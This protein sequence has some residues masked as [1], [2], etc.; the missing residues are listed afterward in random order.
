[1]NDMAGILSV[2]F[3]PKCGDK[4]YNL[5]KAYSII[6]QYC[7][8]QLDL[9]VLPE[10][11]TTS[12]DEKSVINEP[13]TSNG[14]E[15][16]EYMSK[17]AKRFNTNI[18]CGSVMEKDGENLYNTAFVL[19]R[20]GNIIAKY[21]KIHLFDYFGGNEGTYTTPGKESLVVQMDFGKVG[22]SMCFDIQFP[23]LYKE[24]NKSGAEIIVSPSAWSTLISDSDED[25]KTFVETW[26]ALNITRAAENLIY[27]VTSNL[28]GQTNQFIYSCGNSMIVNPFGKILQ[29]ACEEEC[30]IYSLVDLEVVRELKKTVP[31]ALID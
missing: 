27:F 19:N 31:L 23:L 20:Q 28:V 17:V 8:K 7:D 5:E 3:N 24:L 25:K 29:N 9:I 18:I 26:R 13:E 16:V 11:F 2:Q 15:V 6:E 12:L 10:F 30:G 1:M 22:V 14:G 21:R 4:K